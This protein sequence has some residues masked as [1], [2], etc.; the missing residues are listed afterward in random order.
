M[1]N[2]VGP[3]TYRRSYGAN[4]HSTSIFNCRLS[5]LTSF[6]RVMAS[7]SP[8]SEINQKCWEYVLDPTFLHVLHTDPLNNSERYCLPSVIISNKANTFFKE[9]W[10][11]NLKRQ[12]FDN[13]QAH[14]DWIGIRKGTATMETRG[15]RTRQ[16]WCSIMTVGPVWHREYAS[17]S[18]LDKKLTMIAMTQGSAPVCI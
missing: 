16:S 4:D 13:L 3:L 14:I 12:I 17:P 7:K 18:Q 9:D 6:Y 5:L 15:R 11:Q 1:N 8:L 2:E 10:V